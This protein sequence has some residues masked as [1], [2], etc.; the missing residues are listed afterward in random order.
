MK[1]KEFIMPFLFGLIGIFAFSPFSIKLLI[2]LSY[3]YLIHLVLFSKTSTLS[4]IFAWGI[5]H[6]GFGMSWIIVSI[7]YYGE[8]H[9]LAASLIFMFLIILLS[10]VFTCPIYLIRKLSKFA[11]FNNIITKTFYVSSFILL[12]ELTKYY[13]L[14][15]VPWLIPGN[16]FLDTYF[17]N[18]YDYFG[19]SFASFTIYL[20]CALLVF[21]IDNKAIYPIALIIIVSV[22]PESKVVDDEVNYPVSIIQPSSDPFLKYDDN[23]SN[24]IEEN[25]IDL[26]N[27]TSIDSKLIVLPE[28]ELPYTLQDTRFKNFLNSAPQSKQIVMGAWSFDDFKLYNTVYSS[29]YGDIYKKRHLVP[30]GEYIPFFSFLRGLIDFFDLPMSNVEKGP[31]SQLNIDSVRNN[32]GNPSNFGGIATPICFDIAFGNTVRKMNKSSLFMINVS[33]DTW[34][35]R[36]IGPHHHLSIARIRAIENNRWIIRA[37]NDGYSA[38]I[39]NN[40][41]IVDY[42]DKESRGVINSKINN[43]MKERTFFNKYGYVLPY[44]IVFLLILW[45]SY[46]LYVYFNK[47]YS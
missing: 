15:G 47:K 5:G 16:I 46:G 11:L 8:T 7:Y 39:A 36:S 37:A 40:G 34:F 45:Q 21:N 10:I 41:T 4:K 23:Y 35:G 9:I 28:A 6:W 20:L 32:D 30:F 13:F 29:K 25:L 44:F 27:K 12:I 19:V 3:A 38:I 43:T 26:I 18:I 2:Y 1:I 22:I 17:Q 42:L 31:K 33:N 24:K 14:N